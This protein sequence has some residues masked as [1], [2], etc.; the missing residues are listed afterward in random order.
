[1]GRGAGVSINGFF[2]DN[3]PVLLP[4]D[5]SRPLFHY[6]D[7]QGPGQPS[8]AIYTY[9]STYTD[10]GPNAGVQAPYPLLKIAN[11][12]RYPGAMTVIQY[13]YYGGR[14]L[15]P[16]HTPDPPPSGYF[17][18]FYPQPFAIASE[19]SADTG[20]MPRNQIMFFCKREQTFHHLL[21]GVE[22]E[23]VC[24]RLARTQ[25]SGGGQ[26]RG[27]HRIIGCVIGRRRRCQASKG[28]R[29]HRRCQRSPRE[30]TSSCQ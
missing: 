6:P 12:P 8:H 11:D 2:L 30:E 24:G 22:L 14:C 5:F 20:E 4:A 7:D 15:P 3:L 23:E 19:K 1:M 26:I 17:Q 21:A 29:R 13:D 27:V 28:S 25:E 16:D 9:G 18:R 10:N